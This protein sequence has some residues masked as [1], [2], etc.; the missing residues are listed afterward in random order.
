M[1]YSYL[2]GAAARRLAVTVVACAVA[3]AL[4]VAQPGG[5]NWTSA[6]ILKL[7]SV[8]DAQ[9][10]PDGKFIA[11]TLRSNERAGRPVSEI[12]VWDVTTGKTQR[13][14]GPR[15]TGASPRWSPDGQW[16][17][18]LGR[19]EDENGLALARL[20]GSAPVFVARVI[21]TNHPLPNTGETFVWAPG[22]DRIAYVSGVPGPEGAVAD[23]DP[24]VITRYLYK[25]TASEGLT[26][27][28]DNRRLQ[29][30]LVDL[31]TREPRQVTE[32]TRYYHSLAWSPK[33]DRVAGISNAEPDSDRVFNYDIFSMAVGGGGLKQLTKT[34]SAEYYPAWSPD[35]ASIAYLATKRALTSSE[36]TM[37]DTHVWV[38][39][40]DG[41]KPTEVGAAVDNRQG[42]PRWSPDG[43]WVYFTVEERGDVPIYRLPVEGGPAERVVPA[44]GQRGTVQ[45]WTVAKD[46]SIAYTM[47]TPSSPVDLYVRDAGGQSKRL[48]TLND[49][50]L[51]PR[52]TGAVESL[53]FKSVDG[54]DVEAFLT[55]PSHRTPT[56]R[57]PLIVIIHGGPHGAQGPAFSLKSQAYAGRGWAS[58]MVN[59]RGSTG[60]GQAF[61]DAIAKDQDGA[62]A[63]DVLAG[64]DAA[65]ARYLWLDGTRLGVE[66]TSYGGQ[67]TNWLVTQTNRFA[68]AIPTSGISNLVSFNY[69]SY[70][71][72]YLAVEFGAYPHENGVMDVLWERSPLRYVSKVTT[73]TLILHGEND[74][75]VPI[76]EAEQWYI[77]LKDV[78]VDT[79]LV[80]YPREGH[81]LR[82]PKHVADALDRSMAWYERAFKA[83]ASEPAGARPK[84]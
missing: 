43:K 67:L 40:A 73:P 10:S 66:G 79:T 21:A 49:E 48:T 16:L 74:N 71:H 28:N 56:S 52:I 42:S 37:E 68:A 81:G 63:K 80:R 11:Y 32:D 26:R 72:D 24:M 8:G 60:Y 7:K 57:Q 59:Y 41:S 35:G 65:L 18:Y 22:S 46:G 84:K 50:L 20:D 36:T 30:W 51:K 82:E 55:L 31:A 29:V 45:S 6:D 27:F 58:L 9:I 4:V 78:G 1:P 76:S 70:Y 5:Q 17:A 62:E 13:I 44:T 54:R 77:A 33:G 25:P 2:P 75:D 12:W 3:S 53:M 23:G 15:D 47:S 64:I 83:K 19:A 38:M 34:K 14:G 61:A 69:T 39:K